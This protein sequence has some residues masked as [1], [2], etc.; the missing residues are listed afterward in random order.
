MLAFAS[1]IGFATFQSW[2]ALGSAALP[3]GAAAG[4]LATTSMLRGR[5]RHRRRLVMDLDG[6]TV[7][8]RDVSS[9]CEDD[10]FESL[11]HS[12]EPWTFRDP[13]DHEATSEHQ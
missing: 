7:A 5:L 3:L 11:P 6:G 12:H 8:V 9:S 2:L 1:F 10:P 4:V 13:S